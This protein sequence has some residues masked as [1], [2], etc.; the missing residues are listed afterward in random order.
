MKKFFYW[1]F[2]NNILVNV[3]SL[4]LV[5]IVVPAVVALYYTALDI[6]GESWSIFID[7]REIHEFVFALLAA[8]TIFVLFVR[9]ISEQLKG[10]ASEKYRLLLEELL[11]FINELVK[12]KRDRFHQKAK[13]VNRTGDVFKQITYPKD[14][15]EYA[16]DGTKTFLSKGFG[17]DRKN[18]CLTIIAGNPDEKKW[19]YEFKCDQQTQHTKAKELLDNN[20]TAKYCYEHGESIFIADLRKGEKEGIFHQSA[21]Y[22]RK[23]SGSIYCRPVRLMVDNIQYV[24]FFTIVVYG[25]L[26]CVPYDL[27]ECKATERILDEISDR[28]ELELFLHS[29]KRYRETGGN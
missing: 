13:N 10:N 29:I 17:V 11:L 15:I 8:F 23:K 12:K 16:L 5:S 28:I 6:W 24:Y 7:Y 21:R 22:N 27:E 19:W 14:Q 25:E 3:L 4:P 1:L 18:I 26:L 9:G 20:S 2:V